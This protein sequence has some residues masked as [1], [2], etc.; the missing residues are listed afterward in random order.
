MKSFAM[1]AM[2]EQT[3]ARHGDALIE[4]R[5]NLLRTPMLRGLRATQAIRP[6]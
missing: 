4:F 2:Q 6:L 3:S 5:G 1:N